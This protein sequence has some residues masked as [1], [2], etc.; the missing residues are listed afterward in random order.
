[1]GR[2]TAIEWPE[3]GEKSELKRADKERG[4]QT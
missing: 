4:D 3:I 2:R 1:M